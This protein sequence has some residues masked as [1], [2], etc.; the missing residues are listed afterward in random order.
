MS[1]PNDTPIDGLICFLFGAVTV[2]V[3]IKPLAAIG[4]STWWW[5]F[6]MICNA[7]YLIYGM[8]KGWA[9]ADPA[10]GLIIAT[11]PIAFY[12]WTYLNA[13]RKYGRKTN[14]HKED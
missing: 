13:W 14:A 11:G 3:V 12:S 5:G 6:F 2:A 4:L 7:A 8:K 1:N 10:N 9:K